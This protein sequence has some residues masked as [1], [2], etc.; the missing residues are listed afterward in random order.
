[1]KTIKKLNLK[2]K[3]ILS[4]P[5]SS[6]SYY[7]V[8]VG[9]V[10]DWGFKPENSLRISNHWGWENRRHCPIIG[11][12]YSKEKL[13]C[14]YKNGEYHR[15]NY[16]YEAILKQI[17]DILYPKIVEVIKTELLIGKEYNHK[18]F[19]KTVVKDIYKIQNRNVVEIFV[20][21]EVKVL[22]LAIGE[23]FLTA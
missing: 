22:D 8:N 10:V 15:T 4:S 1:M 2:G 19:G 12:D 20:G 3:E 23:R 21:K 6:T 14:E 16:D 13:V 9:E 18:V 7:I 17:E 5:Y 11:E